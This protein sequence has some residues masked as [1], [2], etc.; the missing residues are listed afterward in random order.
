MKRLLIAVVVAVS[1]FSVQAASVPLFSCQTEDSNTVEALKDTD[2]NQYTFRITKPTGKP[3]VNVQVAESD[4]T[5]VD[6]SRDQGYVKS[7]LFVLGD[8]EYSVTASKSGKEVQGDMEVA[9]MGTQ[10]YYSEC[11]PGTVKHKLAD[12]KFVGHVSLVK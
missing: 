2:T 3:G 6:A 1:S 10:V 12:K 8:I 5:L 7:L 4:M 9:R 11:K